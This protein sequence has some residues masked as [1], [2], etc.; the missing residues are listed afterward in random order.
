[1]TCGLAFV[2]LYVI[3]FIISYISAIVEEW[4]NLHTI[5]DFLW[6]YEYGPDNLM[7]IYFPIGNTIAAVIIIC[8]ILYKYLNKFLDIRIK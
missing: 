8:E 3:S 1:M 7:L 5:R 4:K 6:P 2:L